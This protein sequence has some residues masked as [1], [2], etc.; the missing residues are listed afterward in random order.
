MLSRAAARAGQRH[1]LSAYVGQHAA[2]LMPLE[3]GDVA[4]VDAGTKALRAGQSSHDAVDSWLQAGA[5][6]YSYEGLHAKAYLLGSCAFVGSA[7]ASRH[8]QEQLLEAMLHT[9]RRESRDQVRAMVL[10][11]ADLAAEPL[12][13]DWVAHARGLYR[14]PRP[15]VG[16]LGREASRCSQSARTACATPPG[17]PKRSRRTDPQ[18]AATLAELSRPGVEIYRWL[19]EEWHGNR[20]GDVVVLMEYGPAGEAVSPVAADAGAAAVRGP[21]RPAGAVP[22]SQPEAAAAARRRGQRANRPTRTGREPMGRRRAPATAAVSVGPSPVVAAAVAL[23]GVAGAPGK[24]PSSFTASKYSF[25]CGWPLGRLHALRR[26]EARSA[27]SNG[28]SQQAHRCSSGRCRRVSRLRVMLNSGGVLRRRQYEAAHHR[29]EHTSSGVHDLAVLDT[30]SG[31]GAVEEVAPD[32]VESREGMT[33]MGG[34]I[35]IGMA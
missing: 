2:E 24:L 10:D 6:I 11:L 3:D 30:E 22:A 28:R 16:R 17:R 7:N 4:V 5:H 31:L 35:P 1:I 33:P 29:H 34:Q 21:Q 32:A 23:C 13:R 8:S 25:A 12:D 15:P 26:A 14:P 20:T 9:D 19:I 27:S 18:A